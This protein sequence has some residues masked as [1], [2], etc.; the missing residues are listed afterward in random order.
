MTTPG[1]PSAV[2]V[3][4]ADDDA[5]LRTGVAVTLGTAPDIDVVG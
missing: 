5:L 4:L 3:L 2:R 1:A